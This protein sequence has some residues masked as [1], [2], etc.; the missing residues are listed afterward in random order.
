M[1]ILITPDAKQEIYGSE[2]IATPDP[3]TI[4][5]MI[6]ILPAPKIDKVT[7]ERLTGLR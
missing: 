2:E 5:D 3:A 7:R 4:P 1:T 6:V